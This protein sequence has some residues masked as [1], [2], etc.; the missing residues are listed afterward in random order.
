MRPKPTQPVGG[1]GHLWKLVR[2]FD[3]PATWDRARRAPPGHE[4]NRAVR[5]I[6]PI[7]SMNQWELY[8]LTADPIEA[9]K[10]VGPTP[11]CMSCVS[12]CRMQLKQQRAS[13]VPER[14]QPW[15]VRRSTAADRRVRGHRAAGVGAIPDL[16]EAGELGL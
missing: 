14:N 8:D 15:A 6:A 10:P 4:R 12:T 5:R 7:R 16:A 1:A 9:D 3:D 2:T 11:N 13:S